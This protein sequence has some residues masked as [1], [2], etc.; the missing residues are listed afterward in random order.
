[1]ETIN[2][3]EEVRSLINKLPEN[4][5]WSDLI[6]AI[7]LRQRIQSQAIQIKGIKRG[8]IIEFSENLNIPDGSEVLIEVP[9]APQIN[10]EERLKRLHQ[11]FGAWKDET[12]LGEVF[13]QI[14]KERHSYLGRQIDFLNN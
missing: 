7:S 13:A 14:D 3:K 2:L 11:V 4:F 1:M 5:T 10:N 9:E 8:N 12:E 6:S